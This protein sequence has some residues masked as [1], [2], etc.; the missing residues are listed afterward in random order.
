MGCASSGDAA[1]AYRNKKMKGARLMGVFMHTRSKTSKVAAIALVVGVGGLAG[2]G[3]VATAAPTTVTVMATNTFSSFDPAP[4]GGGNVLDQGTILEGLFGY[5]PTNQVVPKIAARWKVSDGGQVWTIWL[6][7]NARWSNGQPVT[8][9]DFYYAWM[10]L[11]SPQDSTG[12]IWGSVMNWVVNSYAYH[13]GQVPA[14]AV[15]LKVINP[16]EL[17]LTLTGPQNIEGYLALAGSM[18]LYPPDV[19]QHPTD[20][21][22]PQYFVGDGPYVP[23]SFTPDGEVVLVRNPYY[24]G[25]PGEVNVGN[26]Q[27]I[28]LIP[29]SSVPVED[30]VSNVVEADAISAPADF[31][32]A[33]QRFGAYLHN[34]PAA[35]I[36]FL[37]YDKSA[38]A[39]PLDNQLVRE[40]IA[41]AINRA[42]IANPVLNGMVVPTSIP[43]IP[44]WPGAN[45]EHN[46]YPYNVAKA[47][48]LLAKA[49]YPDGRGMPTLYLYCQTQTSS[50]ASV[51][52]AEAIAQELKTALNLNFKI[53]PMNSTLWGSLN[54]RGLTQGILPGYYIGVGNDNWD[55]PNGW[56]IQINQWIGASGTAT[57]G[58][59]GP[60]AFRQYFAPIYFNAYDP[61]EVK[62]WGNPADPSMGTS[63]AQ[64]QPL[65]K[66]AEQAIPYLNAWM[67]RQP[68]LYQEIANPPGTPTLNQLL[69][70][71]VNAYKTATTPAAKHQAWVNFWEWVG[72][73]STGLGYISVGLVDQVY[74]YQHQP[75]LEYDENLWTTEQAGVYGTRQSE[76]LSAQ[77]VNAILQSAYIIPLNYNE[78]HFLERPWVQGVQANPYLGGG[79]YQFQYIRVR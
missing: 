37:A 4:W 67:S 48:A 49:G 77:I 30:F 78:V 19:E 75:A 76:A 44:G 14:S 7:R 28:N 71:Y 23:K 3:N 20:W 25:H 34:A 61:T 65:I 57:A 29:P 36:N 41:M 12:A 56:P 42:P 39:S 13:A 8:A 18:P 68:K 31:V 73:Y 35:S 55:N 47:R 38:L 62:A 54:W 58:V 26:V 21:Y 15:G 43:A 72:S 5:S 9:N 40:A 69:Q 24:V 16:Y 79:L 66:A 2:A 17:Q 64:W 59:I 60:A 52:M 53:E 11:I 50:P 70:Q 51:A 46:P 10:R 74:L 63:F 6:R 22:L 27:Q 1:R 45:L 33:K 32:Y